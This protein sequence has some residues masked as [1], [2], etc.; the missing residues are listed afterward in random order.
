MRCL[1]AQLTARTL[2]RHRR[3]FSER[4]I[5]IVGGVLFIFFALTTLITLF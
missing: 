3:Y 5:G 4:V 2:H 1:S